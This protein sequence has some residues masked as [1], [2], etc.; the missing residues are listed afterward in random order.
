MEYYVI[1]KNNDYQNYVT[2]FK[3]YHAWYISCK[4]V[5]TKYLEWLQLGKLYTWK[6]MSRLNK[7]KY[8]T[9]KAAK[10]G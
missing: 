10:L 7:I 8:G 4:N 6:E 9:I 2:T 5:K 1:G 3:S